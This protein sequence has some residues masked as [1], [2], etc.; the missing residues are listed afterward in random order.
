ME[1]QAQTVSVTLDSLTPEQRAQL[2]KEHLASVKTEEMTRRGN[3]SAYDAIRNET[4]EELYPKL[5][6]ASQRLAEIKNEVFEKTRQL[7]E[8][9]AELLGRKKVQKSDKF[10]NVKN[11][12]FIQVGYNEVDDWGTGAVEAKEQINEWL[13]NKITGSNP[14]IVNLVKELLK[15]NKDG[16]MNLQN[17]TVLRNSA[18]SNNEF[19]L[20][21]YIDLML[22]SYSKKPSS[23]FIKAK[24]K[25]A[26]H[27][28]VD[29][30]L[31]ITAV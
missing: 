16:N 26:N 30:G 17:V 27:Q 23:V 10:T 7:V 6:E 31:S 29:L 15:A 25:D 11:T 20:T 24:H 8:M 14:I 12:I 5:M 18:A 28:W 9:K 19:E 21:G 3:I 13:T 2:V 22:E 1:N 4:I